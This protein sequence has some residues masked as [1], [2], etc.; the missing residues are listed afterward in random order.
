MGRFTGS[1]S[2]EVLPQG[3]EERFVVIVVWQVCLCIRGGCGSGCGRGLVA[4]WLRENI[5]SVFEHFQA[6]WSFWSFLSIFGLFW[7]FSDVFGRLELFLFEELSLSS[8][9]YVLSIKASQF[10]LPQTLSNAKLVSTDWVKRCLLLRVDANFKKCKRK[11]H[12]K[13]KEKASSRA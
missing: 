4:W 2:V 3:S 5:L 8:I 12:R 11:Q 13:I 6:F 9:H 1:D 7:T 10:S